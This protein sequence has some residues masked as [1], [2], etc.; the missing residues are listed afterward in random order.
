MALYRNFRSIYLGICIKMSKWVTYKNP[1]EDSKEDC[2][3]ATRRQGNP[4]SEPPFARLGNVNFY[5]QDSLSPTLIVQSTSTLPQL[6]GFTNPW[7]AARSSSTIEAETRPIALLKNVAVRAVWLAYHGKLTI[8]G[9]DI[10]YSQFKNSRTAHVL[11][12]AFYDYSVA[13]RPPFDIIG[14]D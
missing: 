2:N 14:I 3:F 10:P 11:H 9:Q 4:A 1:K 6:L 8:R 13:F 7:V 5:G 12:K